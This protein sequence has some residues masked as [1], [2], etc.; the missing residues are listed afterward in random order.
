VSTANG[1]HLVVNGWRIY[2]HPL[3]LDQLELLITEVEA[4]RRK[5]PQGYG[6]R[7]ASKR[8]AAI[9]RLMLRDI[10]QDPTR[11]E[12]QQGLT[13]GVENRHWRRVKFFQQYRLFFRFH[14]RSKL[15]V[16][17]W[18]N[19]TGTKRAYGSKSDA[20]RIFEAMLSRGHPPKDWEDLMAE[21]AQTASRMKQLTDRLP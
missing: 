7:N 6:N 18:V 2:A 10:P 14:S 20:Y 11:K 19:D 5:D 4:L 15:I 17:G 3:F 16:L 21:A 12:Y 1:A 8:L 9:S 13:L